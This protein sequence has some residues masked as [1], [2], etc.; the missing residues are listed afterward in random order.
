MLTTPLPG[1]VFQ[2]VNLTGPLRPSTT[3]G[4]P[5]PP[6]ATFAAEPAIYHTPSYDDMDADTP[7]VIG[8]VA[9]QSI[10]I[11]GSC[12]LKRAGSERCNLCG[13]AHFRHARV[14][15]HI[16]SETQVRNM[17]AALK[18]S[19]EAGHLVK[20]ARKYLTGVKGTLVQKKKVELEKRR[21]EEEAART[22]PVQ[23]GY[24][25]GY[26]Y[27]QPQAQAQPQGL[28]F[29]GQPA[30]QQQQHAPTA[31]IHHS[32]DQ[33]SQAQQQQGQ[34]WQHGNGVGNGVW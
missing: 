6:S 15:P 13:I 2:R 5:T 12:P 7:P 33:R 34:T 3:H 9:C 1:P 32:Q 14:C 18:E 10:H 25:Y 17:L 22:G 29:G 23:N 30:Q 19:P 31:Q 8:C 26:P 20:E 24:G 4:L 11:L 28:G 16:N 21:R 27:A